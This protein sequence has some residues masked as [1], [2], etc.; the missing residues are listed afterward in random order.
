MVNICKICHN[1]KG[2][3]V[4]KLYDTEKYIEYLSTQLNKEKYIISYKSTP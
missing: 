4:L 1:K 3:F 2:L